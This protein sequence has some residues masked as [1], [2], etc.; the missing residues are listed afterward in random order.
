MSEYYGEAGARR[1]FAQMIDNFI[2]MLLALAGAVGGW[3]LTG[4]EAVAALAGIAAF[5]GYYVLCEGL[6][7]R[8]PGK[9]MTSLIVVTMDGY[10]IG[11]PQATL[12]TL[13]RLVEV[14][15]ILLGGLP[16]GLAILFSGQKQRLGDMV[17]GTLVIRKGDD[18]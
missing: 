2:A 1:F 5:L 12:R 16:A 13:L 18:E 3:E 4:I 17:A 9:M 6:W 15:P 11:W 7:S 8:T 14:N 10:T